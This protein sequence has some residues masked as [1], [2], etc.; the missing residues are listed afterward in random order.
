ML[1]V[2]QRRY[3]TLDCMPSSIS[4]SRTLPHD[5]Q[6]PARLR[7]RRQR[8]G[9]SQMDLAMEAGVK[10]AVFRT[11]QR[12]EAGEVGPRAG[13]HIAAVAKALGVSVAW[14]LLGE[15]D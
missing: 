2:W 14:L 3:A 7:A 1:F 12:W 15:E 10:P 9:W 5:D 6:F 11:I 8:F 4:R 13:G